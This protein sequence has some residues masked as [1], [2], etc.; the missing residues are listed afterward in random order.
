M[1]SPMPLIHSL[2]VD[3][4]AGP[5]SL[6]EPAQRLLPDGHD[7]RRS[8]KPA[9]LGRVLA[10]SSEESSWKMSSPTLQMRFVASGDEFE[11]KRGP[12]W[13]KLTTRREPE[14]R[15]SRCVEGTDEGAGRV[16]CPMHVT[17]E[18]SDDAGEIFLV[19]I[20]DRWD[21]QGWSCDGKKCK[22]GP[23]RQR[24]IVEYQTFD[25]KK[26]S[27]YETYGGGTVGCGCYWKTRGIIYLVST[28]SP[29]FRRVHAT[30]DQAKISI[31]R[32]GSDG[33]PDNFI[34]R[35][36]LGERH[37]SPTGRWNAA[38]LSR[39]ALSRLVSDMDDAAMDSAVHSCEVGWNCCGNRR[40]QP[41]ERPDVPWMPIDDS[42]PVPG[43][44]PVHVGLPDAPWTLGNVTSLIESVKQRRSLQ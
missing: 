10:G 22:C 19:H 27:G 11:H 38:L 32:I 2:R 23:V 42:M 26:T 36:R 24:T 14:K 44:D 29:V 41:G 25:T 31:S 21:K 37:D 30:L 33:K 4:R 20:V 43:A 1:M 16:E 17:A 40:G 8:I 7:W 3:S 34:P 12:G 35:A 6:T 15:T 39:D 9:V 5:T 28:K 18:L 13:G